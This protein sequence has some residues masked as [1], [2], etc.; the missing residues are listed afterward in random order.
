MVISQ[1]VCCPL[2]GLMIENSI[3]SLKASFQIGINAYIIARNRKF[4]FL[5]KSLVSWPGHSVPA[6]PGIFPPPLS[7]AVVALL[8]CAMRKLAEG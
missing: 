2:N 7:R 5:Q 1:D 8:P 3:N 4:R 6:I